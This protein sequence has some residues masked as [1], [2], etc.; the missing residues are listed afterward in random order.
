MKRC[1]APCRAVTNGTHAS[2]SKA[3]R[4]LGWWCFDGRELAVG[5]SSTASSALAS[6]NKIMS[7]STYGSDV[8]C[9]KRLTVPTGGI[10]RVF[11]LCCEAARLL[12]RRPVATT[13]HHL[14]A[15]ASHPQ[16]VAAL[17]AQEAFHS[18]ARAVRRTTRS[19]Q[20]A[21]V[22]TS[23]APEVAHF[24]AIKPL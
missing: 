16:A 10:L 2:S 14:N 22:T 1:C 23:P 13:R 20:A 7:G 8:N 24:R 15:I 19:A 21:T 9:R 18:K 4:G 17:A 5:T 11:N 3:S 6:T 12:A